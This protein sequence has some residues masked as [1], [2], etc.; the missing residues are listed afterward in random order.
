MSDPAPWYAEGLRFTCTQC[1]N[2]CRGPEPGYV[3]VDA[4]EVAAIAGFLGIDV[5]E[6]GKRYLR[7][8]EQRFVALA[9]RDP[10]LAEWVARSERFGGLEGAL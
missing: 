3:E 7:R 8:A 9:E 6:F 10:L 5:R 2:C 4:D 1:G